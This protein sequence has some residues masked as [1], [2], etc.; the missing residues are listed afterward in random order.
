VA[1]ARRVGYRS[2][3]FPTITRRVID[4]RGR[5]GKLMTPPPLL[6]LNIGRMIIIMARIKI[7]VEVLKREKERERET[8]T[9]TGHKDRQREIAVI[10]MQNNAIKAESGGIFAVES[11]TVLSRSRF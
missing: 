3:C 8:C 6:F 4:A 11:I 1:N 2:R 9:R 7:S 10:T 5:S